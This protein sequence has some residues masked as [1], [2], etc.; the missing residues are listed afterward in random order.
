MVDFEVVPNN[1]TWKDLLPNWIDEEFENGH[2]PRCPT[3]P[4][5]DFS[6]YDKVDLVVAQL[7]CRRPELDWNRD[8]IRLQVH[9]VAASLAVKKGKRNENGK[10]KLVFTS[11]CEPMRDIFRCDDLMKKDG[12]WW[13]YEMD[14]M[15]L[16]EKV[17]I[18]PGT[19][20]LIL[21]LRNEGNY[22]L[23]FKSF[24]ILGPLFS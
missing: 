12:T 9:L 15:R 21:P 4:M 1:I 10:V 3:I 16:E 19:C 23:L 5:P 6:V 20:E 14:A 18:P 22:I 24:S 8:V 2:Q 11:Q 7:P 17:R 13:M